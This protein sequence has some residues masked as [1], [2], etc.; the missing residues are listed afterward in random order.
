MVLDRLHSSGRIF[1][2]VK[3][4]LKATRVEFWDELPVEFWKNIMTVF[5]IL[6]TQIDFLVEKYYFGRFLGITVRYARGKYCSYFVSYE[7]WFRAPS[8][9]FSRDA[10]LWWYSQYHTDR[11]F[12]VQYL[13]F[14]FNHFVPT[15]LLHGFPVCRLCRKCTG[16]TWKWKSVH[17]RSCGKKYHVLRSFYVSYLTKH[18]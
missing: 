2:S 17:P 12:P 3:S 13:P 8:L 9:K 7:V 10:I 14:E 18:L 11:R 15:E 6:H 5:I 16:A 4:T 1:V